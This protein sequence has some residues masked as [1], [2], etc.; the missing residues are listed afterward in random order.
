VGG[1]T[2]PAAATAAATPAE[3]YEFHCFVLTLRMRNACAVVCLI[4]KISSIH[5]VVHLL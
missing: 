1:A 4:E 3:F 5:H 2:R